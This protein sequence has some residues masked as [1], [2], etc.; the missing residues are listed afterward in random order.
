MRTARRPGRRHTPAERYE[1]FKK[2]LAQRAAAI[3]RDQFQGIDS[4]DDWKRR[5][6]GVRR[7]LL[8]MLGLDPLPPRTPLN[9][10]VTGG[11]ERDGYR[12]ENI[13][14]ESR[15]KLY[16]T[17]NLYLPDHEAGR[18]VSAH[19]L[20]HRALAE[21]GRREGRISASWNLVCQRTASWPLCS[22]PSS[23][24]RFPGIHH[25]I[26][27]LGMWHWLSLGYAP[28]GVEVWNA[29]R[30]L[31]YLET[32]PEVDRARAGHD[33]PLGRR[34]GHLVHRGR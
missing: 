11:F 16:V 5:A 13:V 6:P 28:A 3:T 20:C 10:R 31:D 9:A 14:F 24:A 21:P 33:R 18:E 1:L 30:A 22:T 34:R 27:D 25:G 2:N 19:R 32:R 7:Q 8:D 26:H 17:G 12:V 4:L 23:S 15:P 29:I